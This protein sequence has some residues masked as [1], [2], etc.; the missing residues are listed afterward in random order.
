MEIEK[1]YL[2]KDLPNLSHYPVS[3]ISQFYLSFDPEIR[4]R[5]KNDQY[6]ITQKSEGTDVREEI[7]TEINENAFNI[8]RAL[9]KSKAIKKTRYFIAISDNLTAELDVYHDDLDGLFTVEVEFETKEEME[10]F[11]APTWF[12]EDISSNF[13]YKNK[14]LVKKLV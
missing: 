4:L 11:V 8:L 1:K 14:N 2:V 5:Q 7:E 13:K 3:E 10:K 9:I 6:F 12:G